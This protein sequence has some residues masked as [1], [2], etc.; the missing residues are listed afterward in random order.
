[1]F[2]INEILNMAIQ[3]EKNGEAV[4][5][6]SIEQISDPKLVSLLEWMADEE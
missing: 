3:I 6:K 1:M 4:Y 2:T 5:R